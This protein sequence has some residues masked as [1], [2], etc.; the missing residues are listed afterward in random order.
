MIN[1][2]KT[3]QDKWPKT[4]DLKDLT[5]EMQAFVGRVLELSKRLRQ[6]EAEERVKLLTPAEI[7]RKFQINEET[8][9]RW[10]RNGKLKSIKI[11][12]AV[13]ISQVALGEFIRAGGL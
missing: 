4:P 6:R 7:A 10:C 8:V 12:R 3:N 5:P 13:R 11:G 2:Q 1:N 9:R